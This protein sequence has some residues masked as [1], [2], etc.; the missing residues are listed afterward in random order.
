V[1]YRVVPRLQLLARAD[2]IDNRSNGGGTYAYN[3]NSGTGSLGLGQE[4]DASGVANDP[5]LGANLTRF[6]LGT[7]YQI[8]PNTQWKVEYRVDQSTGYNFTDIDGNLK[9]TRSMFGTSVVVSF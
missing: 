4:L 6:S 5:N 2:Y 8:N 9:Q 3:A 7:N 1:S